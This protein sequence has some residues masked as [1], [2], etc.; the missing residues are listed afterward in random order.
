MS[1]HLCSNNTQPNCWYM[2][3][4][5][6]LFAGDRSKWIGKV[7]GC[8]DVRMNEPVDEW[9]DTEMER[10]RGRWSDRGMDR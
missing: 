1:I 2:G 6:T 5:G 7:D 10:Y 3:K 9:I 8:R 4:L